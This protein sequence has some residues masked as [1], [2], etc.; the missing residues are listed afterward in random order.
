MLLFRRVLEEAATAADAEKILRAARVTVATTL[1]VLDAQGG[2]FVA[3]LAPGGVAFRRPDRSTLYETNHFESAELREDVACP[4]FA[5]LDEHFRGRRGLDEAGILKVLDSIGQ[6][7][8]IQSMIFFPAR[9]ALALST[10][11]IPATKGR[12]VTLSREHLFPKP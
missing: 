8:T 5:W 11:K 3:E 9:R 6:S 7:I 10:G 2:N 4:R 12:Y 1:M